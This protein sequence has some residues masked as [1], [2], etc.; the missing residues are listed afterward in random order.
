[1]PYIPDLV[2]LLEIYLASRDL[3]QNIWVYHT[4]YTHTH[5]QTY[6]M[7]AQYK[8][9]M[10]SYTHDQVRRR[11]SLVSRE[12]TFAEVGSTQKN[13]V[14]RGPLPSLVNFLIQDPVWTA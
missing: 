1:M 9:Q 11:C 8:D 2:S 10:Y 7:S 6:S 5:I 3:D 4:Q 13:R 12:D 14:C